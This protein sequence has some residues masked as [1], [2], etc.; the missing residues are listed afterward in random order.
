MMELIFLAF[1][2]VAPKTELPQILAT[3]PRDF[4]ALV[5]PDVAL[6]QMG[7]ATDEASLMKLLGVEVKDTVKGPDLSL[8]VKDL[9]A[10]EFETRKKAMET[11]QAAGIAARPLLEEAAKSDDP[12]VSMA[13]RELLKAMRTAERRGIEQGDGEYV[14][15][16]FAIR[17]LEQKKSKKALPALRVLAQGSDITIREAAREAISVIEGKGLPK[18]SA[19]K[20]LEQVRK[21]LSSDIA[22]VGVLDCT[23]NATAKTLMD[24][25]QPVTN[26]MMAGDPK[27]RYTGRF[28]RSQ[29]R[30]QQGI[31][32]AIALVGN[33][34]V[35]SVTMIISDDIG[36]NSGYVG[37]IFKGLCDPKRLGG[38]LAKELRNKGAVGDYTTYAERYGPGICVMDEETVVMS[39]GDQREG[40]HIRQMMEL[41]L[42]KE[43]KPLSPVL[44]QAFEGVLKDGHLL[45]TAGVWP[46]GVVG[47]LKP[48]LDRAVARNQNRQGDWAAIEN[49]MLKLI[50]DSFSVKIAL[51][52]I[53]KKGNVVVTAKCADAKSA[54]AL[55]KSLAS[56][57][58]QM[59][60]FMVKR[61]E[62]RGGRNAMWATVFGHKPNEPLWK[63]AAKGDGVSAHAKI[64][65]VGELFLMD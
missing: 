1:L 54:T 50:L 62:R 53:D 24:Y 3:P 35:D 63:A 34:R 51:G 41:L 40:Q 37:W 26:A 64:A 22:L 33:M 5:A 12:E 17:L 48:E 30:L 57:D 10:V 15:R 8:A 7:V 46:K 28:N 32:Q 14:K 58:E 61:V 59:R 43:K 29:K 39:V 38:L 56:M 27:G 4:A 23:R 11:L 25:V 18:H 47:L 44:N 6:D 36:D 2:F 52:Y 42:N 31:P 45:G 49:A 21:M 55:G 19:K 16:L 9:G 65:R 13:A 60:A 20:G